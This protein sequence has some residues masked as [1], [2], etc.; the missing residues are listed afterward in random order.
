MATNGLQAEEDRLVGSIVE[1]AK[2][3]TSFRVAKA[4][5]GDTTANHVFYGNW[6][7]RMVLSQFPQVGDAREAALKL[8]SGALVEK[9]HEGNPPTTTY[10]VKQDGIEFHFRDSELSAPHCRVEYV[11][12][13]VPAYTRTV[14]KVICDDPAEGE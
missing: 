13:E 7:K 2:T 10:I 9:L 14:A 1:G 6:L 12:E 3:L 4:L 11:E 5:V 8:A